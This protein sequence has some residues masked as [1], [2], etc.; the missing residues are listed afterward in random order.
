[1][2]TI[3]PEIT[4]LSE[5]AMDDAVSE[6]PYI[7]DGDAIISSVW[8]GSTTPD[9]EHAIEAALNDYSDLL[10]RALVLLTTTS[11]V[12]ERIR[13]EVDLLAVAVAK[14][15]TK[16]QEDASDVYSPWL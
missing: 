2:N 1:M 7:G 9:A 3:E 6:A 12:A 16:P 8:A 13:R 14:E 5:S 11:A 15:L 4:A 10:G